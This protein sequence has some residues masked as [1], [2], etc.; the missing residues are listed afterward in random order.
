MKPTQLGPLEGANLNH[1]TSK[2]K[3]YNGIKPTQLGPLKGA[4]LNHWTSKI[5]RLK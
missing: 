2:I 4:N 3:G 5:K 1:W